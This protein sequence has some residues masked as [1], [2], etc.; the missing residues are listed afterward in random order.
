VWQ[1]YRRSFPLTGA[2]PSDAP[3]RLRL[4]DFLR[5]NKAETFFP[6]NVPK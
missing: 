1:A 3:M 4:L 2:Q 5:D 6:L